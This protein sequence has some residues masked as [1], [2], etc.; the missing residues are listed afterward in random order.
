MVLLETFTTE[1]ESMVTANRDRK[2]MR[3]ASLKK[4]ISET[5]GTGVTTLR[6]SSKGKLTSLKI[7]SINGDKV[8]TLSSKV[9][10][11]SSKI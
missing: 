7:T 5:S 9:D 3:K 4:T 8:D 6:P 2:F 11:L 10:T 1:I